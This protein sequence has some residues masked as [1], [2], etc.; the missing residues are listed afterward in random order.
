MRFRPSLG[1][2]ERSA[3][4]AVPTP[5]RLLS[6]EGQGC[7]TTRSLRKTSLTGKIFKKTGN[8]AFIF[9]FTSFYPPR[10][11]RYTFWSQY[12]P[13]KVPYSLYWR[14]GNRSSSSHQC[15]K[16]IHTTSPIWHG[17]D[18][19]TPNSLR[20]GAEARDFVYIENF[21]QNQSKSRVSESNQPLQFCRL[22]Y[23]HSTNPT[24]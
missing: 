7:L 4:Q 17:K 8:Q 20:S 3:Q 16:L 15:F 22:Q 19:I 12:I 9:K 21:Y 18:T 23:N 1:I 13:P 6:P 14:C 5:C 11:Y 10:K 2:T 24:K